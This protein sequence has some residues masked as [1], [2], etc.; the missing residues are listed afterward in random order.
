MRTFLVSAALCLTLTAC[1]QQGPA[2]QAG[3]E[4]DEAVESLQRDAEE[5]GE[6]MDDAIDDARDEAEAAAEELRDEVDPNS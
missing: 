1:E 2:E 6:Q 3:E 4:L 5:M